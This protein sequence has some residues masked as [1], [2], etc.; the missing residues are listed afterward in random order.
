MSIAL[1][2]RTDEIARAMFPS[3]GALA[4]D[5]YRLLFARRGSMS[6][7][8]AHEGGKHLV[9]AQHPSTRLRNRGHSALPFVAAA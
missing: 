8:R 7:Y 1:T 6:F 9:L 3:R 4:R 5:S 2:K